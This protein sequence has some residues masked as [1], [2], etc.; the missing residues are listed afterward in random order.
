MVCEKR[1]RLK[2][3][4]L[5]RLSIKMSDLAQCVKALDTHTHMPSE[6]LLLE[7]LTYFRF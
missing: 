3:E 5:P 7:T 2:G 1:E 4:W 6:V